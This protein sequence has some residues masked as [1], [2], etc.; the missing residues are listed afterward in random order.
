ML[1]EITG[2]DAKLWYEKR[3]IL[4]W[5]I[6]CVRADIEIIATE[7]SHCKHRCERQSQADILATVHCRRG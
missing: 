2:F 4:P 5:T 3:S 7:S 6:C 1:N